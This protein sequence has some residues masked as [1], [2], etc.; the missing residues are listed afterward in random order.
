MGGLNFRVSLS[1]FALCVLE[2][3]VSPGL[4]RFPAIPGVMAQGLGLAAWLSP[5]Q[6]ERARTRGRYQLFRKPFR[7]ALERRHAARLTDTGSV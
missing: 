7:I 3:D 1:P 2:K 6:C 5:L 4:P